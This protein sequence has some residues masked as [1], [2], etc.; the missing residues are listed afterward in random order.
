MRPDKINILG[1]EYTIQYVHT[2][3]EVDN[4]KREALWG[5]IDLWDRTIRIYDNGRSG[6]DIL[7]TLLH[8]ILH[9]IG[10]ALMLKFHEDEGEIGLLALALADT[11][12]RNG[13]LSEARSK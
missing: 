13:W 6:E 7:R 10:A 2:P 12:N 3:S 11:L 1:I 4:Q 8:E 5:Q 9:G